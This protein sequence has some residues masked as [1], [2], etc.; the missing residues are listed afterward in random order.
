MLGTL[1]P[2]TAAAVKVDRVAHQGA[3]PTLAQS[4]AGAGT[5][6]RESLGVSA[7]REAGE[8]QRARWAVKVNVATRATPTLR[9]NAVADPCHT[10]PR[11]QNGDDRLG[12]ALF[13]FKMQ[14]S[15]C[16]DYRTVTR[17]VT[18]VYWDL[19]TIGRSIGWGSKGGGPIYFRCYVAAGSVLPCAGNYEFA[20]HSWRNDLTGRRCQTSISEDENY[21]GE[22][23]SDGQTACTELFAPL[24]TR[25]VASSLESAAPATDSGS[26]M[27]ST[28]D[29]LHRWA[30][31]VA[32]GTLLTTASQKQRLR[33]IATSVKHVGYGIALN[34]SNGWIGHTGGVRG[35]QSLTIY[36]PSPASHDRGAHQHQ[37][38]PEMR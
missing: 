36:L 38:N 35:Y 4:Q 2:A 1:L 32:T 16:W 22:F 29:D 23:F 7:S 25:P 8:L 13:W 20:T 30:R 6:T 24:R 28:L 10:G 14:T 33:F 27:I 21:R 26:A 17:H 5:L 11:Q 34:N 37:H 19:D 12:F 15:W 9:N 18:R 3:R 31:D